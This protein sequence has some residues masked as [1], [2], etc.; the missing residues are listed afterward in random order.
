[1]PSYVAPNLR[2]S[3]LVWVPLKIGWMCVG[4]MCVGTMALEAWLNGMYFDHRM[5][6]SSIN[7]INLSQC[8]VKLVKS[9]CATKYKCKVSS[10]GDLLN[11][12]EGL[13]KCLS[14]SLLVLIMSCKGIFFVDQIHLNAYKL[15]KL[16]MYAY[17]ACYEMTSSIKFEN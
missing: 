9:K 5:I 15:I 17:V 7:L 13:Q 14:S 6:D 16:D 4:W 12:I 10:C 1:M 8:Q 3:K 11:I 2:G